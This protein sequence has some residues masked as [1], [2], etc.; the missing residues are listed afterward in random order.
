MTANANAL[1][2]AVENVIRNGIRFSET[3]AEVLVDL[4]VIDQSIATCVQVRIRDH[5]PGVPEDYLSAIFQPFF[6]VKRTSGSQV[7]NG[8]GLAI[9]LEAVR[10]HRGSISATNLSPSGLEVLIEIPLDHSFAPP[11]TLIGKSSTGKL[12]PSEAY[13]S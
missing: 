12:E 5:G 3:G 7:G 1:R 8:L 4:R 6:Q 11:H 2:S 13:K 9:A 10:M